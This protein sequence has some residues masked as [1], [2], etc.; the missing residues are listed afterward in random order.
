MKNPVTILLFSLL[1]ILL[2]CKVQEGRLIIPEA[3]FGQIRV[4]ANVDSAKILLN[5]ADTGKLTPSLLDSIPIGVHVIQLVLNNYTSTPGS[6]L[7][8]VDANQEASADFTLDII[9]DGVFYQISSEPDSALLV[10]DGIAR[11]LTPQALILDD[12]MH[13][14]VLKKSGFAPA[15]YLI[16]GSKGDSISLEEPLT[17]QRTVLIEHFSNTGC[18][19][20][21]EADTT[22][23]NVLAETGVFNTVS[24][25]F[26]LSFPSPVDPMYLARKSENDARIQ[27]Y[28]VSGAPTIYVDGVQAMGAFNLTT[29]LREAYTLRKPLPPTGILEIFDYE[30]SPE[31]VRGRVRVEAVEA[32]DNAALHIAL[33]EREVNYDVPPGVNGQVFFFD[34]FRGSFPDIDGIPLS[35][36]SG[37]IQ[38]VAFEFL[39]DPGWMDQYLEVVAF[40]QL[41]SKE[42]GQAAWTL[43]P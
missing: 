12:T 42:V 9:L 31:T 14:I 36:S 34:V 3:Q 4:S 38:F 33:I 21:V 17:L 6:L 16:Q 41:P 35:L 22:I 15:S 11:G 26:R 10:I 23:E 27:Y 20:C 39:N 7:V 28:S 18:F 24:L 19:P 29:N 30:V 8:E 5:G 2:S 37:E 25:G 32:L 13:E 1:V 40:I 43:Y